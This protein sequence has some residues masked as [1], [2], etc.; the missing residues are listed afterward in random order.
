M[1]TISKSDLSSQYEIREASLEGE[2]E[3]YRERD[4]ERVREENDIQTDIK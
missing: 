3:R 1:G 4:T 2:R